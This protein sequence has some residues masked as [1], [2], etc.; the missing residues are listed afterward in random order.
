MTASR[1]TGAA[2]ERATLIARR[3]ALQE[4]LRVRDLILGFEGETDY[5]NRESLAIEETAW[6]HV[7]QTGAEPRLA[8]VHPALLQAIP[9]AS[10]HYRG[11]ALLSRKIVSSLAG[12]V[13]SWEIPQSKARVT[14]ER[15]QKVT[16]LYNAVISSLIIDKTDWT[17]ENG[18][19]NVLATIGITADGS[20]RNIIGQS[21][22]REIKR[23]MFSWVREHD[24]FAHKAETPKDSD[25]H[26]VWPLRGG[27]SM[28]FSS[29]P[30][31]GFER[32]GVYTAIIEVKAGKDPAGA[33]ERLGAIKKT[34]DAAPTSCR[35]FLVAGVVTPAMRNGL[36][37][38]N[39]QRDFDIDRLIFDES[40]WLDFMNEIFHYTLRI[41]SEAHPSSPDPRSPMP[42]TI[43]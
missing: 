25:L 11:V 16:R 33:L 10:L 9:E 19:R 31:I 12:S 23:K 35:K 14:T 41:T 39:M 1:N 5:T 32:D 22:E 37:E 26:G 3:I 7:L 13:D 30:D 38:M 4:D 29:E 20:M 2:I 42:Y 24:L 8:F 40:D 34:F 27:I 17:M 15:A 21:G 28:R 36:N 18:Y 6:Q 43:L